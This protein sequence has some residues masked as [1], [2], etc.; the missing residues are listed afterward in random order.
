MHQLIPPFILDRYAAGEFHGS[1]PAVGLFGD[2]SGFSTMTDALMM[3]G[4]EGAEVLANILRSVL[5]PLIES[6]YAQGG[7]VASSAGDAITAL[8]PLTDGSAPAAFRALAAAWNIQ[9]YMLAHAEYA[10]IYQTFKV[11]AKVGLASGDVNWGIILSKK[12]NAGVYY[13]E[14]SA[15]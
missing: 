6:V 9:Q 12:G 10:T 4:Q 5:D 8:F 1:F 14:G 15:V 11:S 13:F 7:F 3:H 2:I